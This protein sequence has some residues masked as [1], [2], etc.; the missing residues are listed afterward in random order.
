LWLMVAL[1]GLVIL[2]ILV[3]CIPIEII[4]RANTEERPKFSLRL[5]WLFG[6]FDRDMRHTARK[7]EEKK[8]SGKKQASNWLQRIK[9]ALEILQTRG[10]LKQ[11]S[12][13]IRRTYRS[14]R[15]RELAANL[16]VDLDNP[17]DTGL[18]FAF[19]APAN[20]I[21][22]YFL[23]YPVKI[24]PSFAGESLI[25]GYLNTRVKLMPI[26]VV[27]SA[28]GL[29]FSIPFLR[30]TRKLVVYRWKRKK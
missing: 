30:A 19:I 8:V 10:L 4:L 27:A 17:A 20:L 1:A 3:L 14:M 21:T 9:L 23:P 16:K 25:N 7:S 22:N 26:R 2:I 29:A 13:F 5:V 28:T 6:L 11:L 24:E 15:V 18:L 12:S